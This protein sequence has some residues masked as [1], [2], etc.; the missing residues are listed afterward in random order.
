MYLSCFIFAP[1]CPLGF[2]RGRESLQ[3]LCEQIPGDALLYSMFKENAEPV[4]CPL[5]GTLT[6]HLRCIEFLARASDLFLF[7]LS[8]PFTFT[9]NRGHG[10]CGDPV[11]NIESCTEDSRLLLSF[12]A[13][14]DVTGT[15][16]TVEELTCLATWKDGNSR[17]LVGLVSHHH[18]TSNEERYRCFV[19]EKI[20]GGSKEAEY[21]LA[22]SGDATCNGLDSA[23]VCVAA[24]GGSEE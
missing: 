1:I 24:D 5:K 15:E 2:C 8:G 11:S 10:E 12:Q 16:S 18:A 7:P 9:Y 21:K 17:Y 23:E 20:A 3:N 14:P 6:P 4:R 13:C 22:Q 19:Y